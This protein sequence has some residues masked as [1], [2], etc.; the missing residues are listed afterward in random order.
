MNKLYILFFIVVCFK[1]NS[2]SCCIEDD[3]TF[4]EKFF[5][6]NLG[7]VFTCKIIS[8]TETVNEEFISKA[9]I[10]YAYFGTI[11][12]KIIT[13]RTGRANTST[14]GRNLKIGKTYLIYSGGIGPVFGCCTMCDW[15]SK[16]ITDIP[17]STF[18]IRLVKKFSDIIRNKETG[19][20]QFQNE[21]GD[22]IAEGRFQKGIATGVWKHYD[23]GNVKVKYDFINNQID[24]YFSNG[25]LK[26]RQ[27][28]S[29][30]INIHE[31]YSEKEKELLT[32]QSIDSLKSSSQT[33]NTTYQFY[34]NRNLKKVETR[35]QRES[36]GYSYF[37]EY[38]INGNLQQEGFYFKNRRIKTWKWYNEDG[39]FNNEF[40][41]KDGKTNQ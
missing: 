9:K 41:Y 26:L 34:D 22:L 13:L 7:A 25:Y 15:G 19:N 24:K 6:G 20:F 30:S 40:D 4:T 39:S 37:K 17:D 8:S 2:F 18:E 3:R 12:A 33:T 29:D 31:Y 35:E 10:I 21:I 38:Y 32:V 5:K 36:N 14:G 1:T 28:S 23:K 11:E 27:I 16:Q